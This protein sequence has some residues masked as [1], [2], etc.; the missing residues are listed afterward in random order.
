MTP[1]NSAT[2]GQRNALYQPGLLHK[3]RLIHPS[4][5]VVLTV[6]AAALVAHSS[7]DTSRLIG[8]FHWWHWAALISSVALITSH[9]AL[10][11]FR[12]GIEALSSATRS[13]A[14]VLVWSVFGL[15]LFNVVTRYG[16]DFVEADILFGQ[17]TSLAWQSFGLICLAGVNHG[18]RDG[19]NPRIDFWWAGFSDRIKAALDFTLHTMLL[20]PFTA[21][22]VRILQGYAAT[23]LGRRHNGEW[24]DS[25]RVW[26]SWE[27]SADAG[28]LPV[29][30]IKAMLLVGFV[31]F[32][33]QVIAEIIKAG[34]VMIGRD[35]YARPATVEDAG[36][37]TENAENT[38]TNTAN[39]GDGAPRRIE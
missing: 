14:W 12:L 34:F 38:H 37:D 25:W 24:P 2:S 1:E 35:D 32:G 5:W 17:T 13:V 8:N 7:T 28:G 19:I 18:V 6:T 11:R 29:G 39:T 10:H 22:S 36:A 9:R 3:I 4:G 16:N 20:L 21:M 27:S 33:L 30:P 15:Q 23:S 26:E 31:L